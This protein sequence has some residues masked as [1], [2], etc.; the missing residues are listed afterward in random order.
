VDDDGPPRGRIA[1]RRRRE[2]GATPTLLNCACRRHNLD[3]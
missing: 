1:E 3:F 2:F